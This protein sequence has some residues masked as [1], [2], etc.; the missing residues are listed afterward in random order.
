MAEIRII[1]KTLK[2]IP[3]Q[4][5]PQGY[6][7]PVWRYSENPI[8][9]RYP[10][11]N[12]ERIFNSAVVEHE[13]RFVGLFR[14]EEENGL[15]LLRRG[16][17][18]D[19]FHF[20]F[21]KKRLELK[22]ADGSAGN[23]K[24][25]YQYDPRL[26]RIENTYYAIWCEAFEGEFPS[27][28]FAKSDDLQNFY[29]L[30]APLLPCNRNGVLFPRKVN[31]EY[32]LL[33]RPSDNG[34]TPFGHIFL[35][36]SKDLEYWGHHTTLIKGCGTK[37]WWNAVKVGA[38]PAPIETSEGWLLFYHGV[39]GNCN[40]LIYSMGVCLLD[41]DDPSKVIYNCSGPV[42]LP[43]T[44][45]EMTGFTPNIIFPCAALCDAQTGRI[46]VYYGGADTVLCL[47]F[48]TAAEIFDFLKKHHV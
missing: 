30:P 2:N 19:G 44:A 38:G 43:E 47:A 9:K 15:P 8:V 45:Y 5:K 32:L 14:A 18:E 23:G 12:V 20:V 4:E 17:S 46:A 3:W 6:N 33:S 36:K 21:D 40:G 41:L 31:G 27:L 25:H 37:G 34:H 10:A 35:S 26:I 28:G 29:R 7:R 16:E 1:G 39:N 13:G 22:N 24:S 48:T 42:L 11:E